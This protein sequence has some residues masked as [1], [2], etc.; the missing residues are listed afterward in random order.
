MF[1]ELP[2]LFRSELVIQGNETPP[3]EKKGESRNQPLRLI[4]HDYASAIAGGEAGVLQSFGQQMR[5]FLE[6]AISQALFLA[7]PVGFDQAHFVRKLIQ[8]VP[9]RFS[10]GLIFRKVQHYRRD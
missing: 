6:V 4:G 7:V 1:E 9:E 8:R 5:A 3:R 2:L 10:N